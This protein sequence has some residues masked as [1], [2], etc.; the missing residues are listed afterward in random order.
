MKARYF[1][2][3]SILDAKDRKY[4]SYGWSSLLSGIALLKK[5][6][7]YIVGDGKT[8]RLGV[9]NVFDDHPPRPI[10]V[11]E[12]YRNSLLENLISNQGNIRSWDTSKIA[13][14][15]DQRDRSL[16]QNS[17][18]SM[19]QNCDTIIWNYNTSGDYSVRSGYWLLT[20]DPHDHNRLHIPP[21]SID[22]KNRVWKL[23]IMPKIKHFLRRS[24]SQ[25][26][27]TMTRL[28]SRG[29][30]VDR[31]CPRCRKE[32]ESI[33][34]ALFSCPFAM[35]VWRL[36]SIPP[37]RNIRFT[38]VF[39]E[40]LSNLMNLLTNQTIQDDQ[41]LM[42]YWFL[43]RIWKA[44][45]N[46][47]FN[48]GRESASKTVL[49]AQAETTQWIIATTP[50]KRRDTMPSHNT[51][52]PPSL[53]CWTAPSFPYIKCNFDA[54]FDIHTQQATAGWIIR[55]HHGLSKHWGSLQLGYAASP[56]EAETKAL[57]AAMQQTWGH[58]EVVNRSRV[59]D[60][61]LDSTYSGY[62]C[63]V[64][65]SWKESDK[66]SGTGWFC[67][68]STEEPPTMGAANLRR[69]L[70]PLH[71]E[72]EALLWEMKCMIGAD[73][74][75]V[76]F[77]TDCSDLVKMVSSPTK[78]PAFLVYL[79]EFQSDKEE[80]QGDSSSDSGAASSRSNPSTN[81]AD[82]VATI[83]GD[84]GDGQLLAGEDVASMCAKFKKLMVTLIPPMEFGEGLILKDTNLLQ[85]PTNIPPDYPQVM[86]ACFHGSLA[87]LFAK[88][89]KSKRKETFEFD[90]ALLNEITTSF[91]VRGRKWLAHINSL[92]SPFNIDKNRW[93]VV[94]IDLPS[95]SLTVFDPTTA[96]WRGSD[97]WSQIDK[98]NFINEAG[99]RQR[100]E[101]LMVQMYEHCCGGIPAEAQATTIAA[102]RK[103]M[104][105][106]RNMM[107]EILDRPMYAPSPPPAHGVAAPQHHQPPPPVPKVE[108]PQHQQPQ[109]P[110][111]RAEY[112]GTMKLMGTMGTKYFYN[113]F[114]QVRADDWR[115]MLEKNFRTT[116]CP[117]EFKKDFA[118]HYLRGEADHW[119]RNVERS[120]PAGYVP[121]WEDFL[122]EF[123][124]KYF[125]RL[126]VRNFG[127]QDMMSRFIRG[128]KAD[129]HNR[130]S[131]RACT[132]LVEL[133]EEAATMER[134]LDEEARDL[135]RAQAKVTKG[136][137]SQKRTWDNRD[138]GPSQNRY[139]KCT[140]CNRQHGGVCWMDS[141]KCFQCGEV[142]HIRENCPEG[143]DNCRKCGKLGHYARECTTF[144]VEG[145]QPLPKRQALGPHVYAVEDQG[146]DVEKDKTL[147][148]GVL[149]GKSPRTVLVKLARAACFGIFPEVMAIRMA[150]RGDEVSPRLGH[151]APRRWRSC[152]EP[153]DNIPRGDNNA[154]EAMQAIRT[155]TRC[156]HYKCLARSTGTV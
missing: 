77:F 45:N 96:V 115:Q 56:L 110:L 99:M 128:L 26:L 30:N 16:L 71:A 23:P 41:K 86:D 19:E 97:G 14:H 146:L 55:D 155:T 122:R 74:Q 76:A 129:I 87:I 136:V 73:N 123:N 124:N 42:P 69:S 43:W 68:S 9:D 137:E 49:K 116:R 131:I 88:F 145:N 12:S 15:V 51:S 20:H 6:S 38:P 92:L 18:L 61:S 152:P 89:K 29:M 93:I 21:G 109:A 102:N 52:P 156:F 84:G 57:I 94:H 35:M 103:E 54:G 83:G 113:G 3:E 107:R 119:W 143:N 144:L 133:V 138:A 114:D 91:K 7:R 79:E 27:A 67:T 151:C 150:P 28:N 153:I 60:A 121:T 50:H 132:S 66:F 98:V 125:P 117:E 70:S 4:Q 72:V 31:T 8:I 106:L 105:E 95:H 59:K 64:D 126:C 13:A 11:N 100:A 148:S 58:V 82:E 33:N 62:R 63:F 154:P 130:S 65:G 80:F 90:S 101:Q 39:E 5:G 140:R 34:H 44:R 108:V 134:G 37:L 40:N 32:E 17:H 47:V 1:R 139:P 24:L 104:Q 142:G 135:K 147:S 141:D 120:L 85:I 2:D 10:R 149:F 81:E 78:W 127:E 53:R 46:F 75:E 111:A 112:F 22:L 36:A 118:V 25:A 48:K